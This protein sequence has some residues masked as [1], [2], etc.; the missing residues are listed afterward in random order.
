MSASYR[1]P[2][3]LLG[4]RFQDQ[5]PCILNS[6]S[7]PCTTHLYKKLVL[8]ICRFHLPQILY[9]LSKFGWKQLRTSGPGK[10]KP[11]LFKG[12]LCSPQGKVFPAACSYTQSFAE[13]HPHSFIQILFFGFFPTTMA[14]WNS[15]SRHYMTHN[16]H[17]AESIYLA[18]YRKKNVQISSADRRER[19]MLEEN[20]KLHK[21]SRK[22]GLTKLWT[23][24]T[25][26]LS[27]KSDQQGYSFKDRTQPPT[28]KKMEKNRTARVYQR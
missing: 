28:A 20:P 15:C 2:L 18:L 26:C 8:Q 9:F 4:D 23:R 16:A 3:V 22:V 5:N 14:E 7:W 24:Q 17:N 19:K 1:F 25:K 13:T 27:H 21:M 10:F 12:Q 6:V 11:T